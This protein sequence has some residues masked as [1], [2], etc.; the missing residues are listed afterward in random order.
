VFAPLKKTV[1]ITA[2]AACPAGEHAAIKNFQQLEA[3]FP[4]DGKPLQR[5]FSRRRIFFIKTST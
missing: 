5:S 1:S 4:P 2:H 3:K